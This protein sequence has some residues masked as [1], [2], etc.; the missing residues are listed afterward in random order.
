[1]NPGGTL[2]LGFLELMLLLLVSPGVAAE[3][4]SAG[5]REARPAARSWRH[6]CH[7]TDECQLMVGEGLWMDAQ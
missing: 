7:G 3:S 5:A 2:R 4:L 1:M 6:R